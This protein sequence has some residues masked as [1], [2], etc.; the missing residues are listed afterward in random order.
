MW[1]R[2]PKHQ[3]KWAERSGLLFVVCLLMLSAWSTSCARKKGSLAVPEVEVTPTPTPMPTPTPEPTPT[4]T[5][6]P[7]PY[8][9]VKR[10]VTVGAGASFNS[11]TGSWSDLVINPVT[12]NPEVI[13]YD[14]TAVISPIA[15]ALKYAR[16]TPQGSWSVE[17]IDANAPVTA[18]TNTCGGGATSAA[19]IGAPNVA[20]PSANQEQIYAI[21]HLVNSGVA[22][23]VVAYAYGTGGASS[24]TSGKG[25]RFAVRGTDGIWDIENAVPGADILALLAGGTTPVLATLQYPIKGVR[26]LV[27][28]SNRVHLLFGVYTVVQNSSVLM[29]TMRSAAGVWKAPTVVTTSFPSA[30]SFVSASPTFAATTGLAKA[31]ISWCKY[32]SGG[33]SSDATGML[34]SL[35]TT[36]NSPAA[37]T[38]PFILRCSGVNADGSCATWQGLDFTSGCSGACVTTTPA[39]STAAANQGAV[40]D[41]T[42]DPVTGKIFLGYFSAAPSLT[43]PATLATGILTTQSSQACDAGLGTSAWSSVRVHPTAAQGTMGFS[44]AADGTNFY[45]ASLA[46]A[47]GTS[48]VLGKQSSALSA[49]WNTNPDQVTIEATT[50]T[51]AGGLSYDS[52]TGVLWGSYGA[53]TAAAAGVVGQDIKVY[54]ALP[55]D[56]VNTG[57]TIPISWV[58]QTN[59]IAQATAVPLLDANIAPN[60]TLGYVYYYQEP[61]AAPGVQSRVYYGFRGGTTYSPLFGEKFVSNAI[62]GLTTFRNGLHPSLAYDS[63]SN[64]VI[65][66]HNQGVAANTGYLMVARSSDQ[67]VSFDLTQVD[68]SAAATFNVGQFNSVDVTADDTVGVAYYDYSTGATGQRLKFAKKTKTGAWLKYIVD[69][70]GTTGAGCSTSGTSATGSHARFLWTSTGRPVIVYQGAVAGVR[71]LKLAY[72][73]EAETS[74]TYTWNCLVLDT[75]GQGAGIRA[76]GIG[77]FLDSLDNPFIIHYE[78]TVGALRAVT[79]PLLVGVLTCAAAGASAFSGERLNYVIGD[80]DAIASRPSIKVDSVG[81]IWVSFHSTAERAIMI[82]SKKAGVWSSSAEIVEATPNQVGSTYTGHYGVLLLNAIEQPMLFY[83]SFENWIRYFSRESPQ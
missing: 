29:Y 57:V 11:T 55:S 6:T 75:D 63:Q 38:Q 21:R 16:M 72:A 66:F 79:C 20:P 64:P 61:A 59:F 77:F 3:I 17:I 35:A 31:S 10:L 47:A 52:T 34:M 40:T 45:L 51:V 73:Q 36:D 14:R 39:S 44:V 19:C 7:T 65:A 60:G 27:D 81:T 62:Q 42:I 13:Y 33:S 43:V 15:G 71:S 12:Q 46:A 26:M 1:I 83:R 32:S 18:I 24:S 56:I 78:F 69:G 8:T 49:N 37:S 25:I 50:N 68:G 53:F 48:I 9:D 22:T 82:A 74:S 80:V 67:G 70:P 4:P 41:L 23:P 28:D 76:E 5:P 54:S 2:G 30:L 58:D